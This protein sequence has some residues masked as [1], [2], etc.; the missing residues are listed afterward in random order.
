MRSTHIVK[1]TD[2]TNALAEEIGCNVWNCEARI[3]K[4]FADNK[5]SVAINIPLFGTMSKW[6]SPYYLYDE[7]LEEI[8]DRRVRIL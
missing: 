1:A 2:R 7:D 8:A 4:R 6:C 5:L 3:L